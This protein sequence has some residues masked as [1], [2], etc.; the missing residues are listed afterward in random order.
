MTKDPTTLSDPTRNTYN[1]KSNIGTDNPCGWVYKDDLCSDAKAHPIPLDDFNIA[2]TWRDWA[3]AKYG[4]N[5]FTGRLFDVLKADGLIPEIHYLNGIA[6]KAQPRHYLIT[7][8]R[9]KLN[10]ENDNE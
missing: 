1:C 10:Q 2:M 6:C 7:A 3:V 8:A 5:T 9:C 4:E